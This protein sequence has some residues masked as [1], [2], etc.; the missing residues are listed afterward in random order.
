MVSAINM[1][2]V[3]SFAIFQEISENRISGLELCPEPPL[4]P[5]VTILDEFVGDDLHGIQRQ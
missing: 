3:P 2:A 5:P 1:K 4:I